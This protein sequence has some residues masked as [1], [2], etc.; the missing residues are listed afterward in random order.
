MHNH[1]HSHSYT[2]Y[3]LAALIDAWVEGHFLKAFLLQLELEQTCSRLAL[4]C[5]TTGHVSHTAWLHGAR[6]WVDGW[7][8]GALW[9]AA[10][11]GLALVVL[12]EEEETGKRKT[13]Q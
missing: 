2:I 5:I 4:E 3:S 8:E 10:V 9:V 13:R 12:R 7:V 1:N 6:R 11:H